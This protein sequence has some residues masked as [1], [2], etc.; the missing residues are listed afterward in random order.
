MMVSPFRQNE[1]FLTLNT[2]T[3]V[4]HSQTPP[5]A[6]NIIERVVNT[7]GETGLTISITK[8]KFLSTKQNTPICLSG[9]H[10]EREEEFKHQGSS[11]D[12]KSGAT[13]EIQGRISLVYLWPAPQTTLD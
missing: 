1:Q 4:L 6:Q 11:I 10:V 5:K 3:M 2:Q 12:A 7:A 13:S 9:E 8:T